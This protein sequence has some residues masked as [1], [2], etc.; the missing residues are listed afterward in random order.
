MFLLTADSLPP[1]TSLLFASTFFL[2]FSLSFSHNLY[3]FFPFTV[4]SSQNFLTH[5]FCH[6][7][8]LQCR[9]QK[10]I[11]LPAIKGK[12]LPLMI[13]L[14]KPWVERLPIP[15]RIGVMIQVVSALLSLTPWYNIYIH[16]PLVLGDYLPP[17][18]SRVWLSICHHDSEVS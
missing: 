18:S 2:F 1:F 4:S 10:V 14:L 15:N 3:S 11:V 9:R 6:L 12:R 17:P 5:Y 16:F 7:I 13:R 8:R